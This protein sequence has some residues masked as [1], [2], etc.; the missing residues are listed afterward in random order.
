M[1]MMK[2]RPNINLD[3]KKT[4]EAETVWERNGKTKEAREEDTR[5]PKDMS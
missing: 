3:R 1:T 2:V 4:H 5:I